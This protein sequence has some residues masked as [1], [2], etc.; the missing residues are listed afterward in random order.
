MPGYERD[1]SLPDVA[2]PWDDIPVS[3]TVEEGR[4]VLRIGYFKEVKTKEGKRMAVLFST[5]DEGPLSGLPFPIQ[6]YVLGTESDPL[7]NRDPNTWRTS[8]GGR[9]LNQLLE[10]CGSMKIGTSLEQ[11]LRRAEQARCQ[12]YVTKTMQQDNRDG[13][14]NQFAGTEQNRITKYVAYGEEMKVRPRPGGSGQVANGPVVPRTRM[15]PGSGE[16]RPHVLPRDEGPR[17]EDDIPA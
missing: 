15:R 10:A 7:C 3:D 16:E 13:T 14:P 2:V 9:Q 11:S 1:Q 17:G 12:V 8:F 4:Y 6:N 5:I